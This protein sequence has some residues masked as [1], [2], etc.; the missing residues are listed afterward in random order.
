MK[1][2]PLCLRLGA[3]GLLLAMGVAAQE[4]ANPADRLKTA[5]EELR[6]LKAEEGAA[7][8]EE[9]SREM[10]R[11]ATREIARAE[12]EKLDR[13]KRD[14]KTA[15]A[16]V[17]ELGS[18]LATIEKDGAAAADP[19]RRQELEKAKAST[20]AELEAARVLAAAREE[21]VKRLTASF[22][23]EDGLYKEKQADL[24]AIQR[25]QAEKVLAA[26]QTEAK[27]CALKCELAQEA[28]K[29]AQAKP[30]PAAAEAALKKCEQ[31]R[32][33]LGQAELMV[34]LARQVLGALELSWKTPEKGYRDP[35]G[36]AKRLKATFQQL[37]SETYAAAVR[38]QG[39]LEPL[40]AGQWDEA[41]ARHLLVRAGFGGTPQEVRKLCALGLH[42]AVDYLVD[43]AFL[44]APDAPFE[45]LPPGRDDALAANVKQLGIRG[46]EGLIS[47]RQVGARDHHG[48]L[49]TWW[50]R[51]MV[52]SPRQLQE[53]LT[54]FWHG[55]FAAQFNA[56]G[57]TYAM[58]RQNQL[59]REHAAGNFGALLYGIVHDPAMLRYLDNNRNVKGK[60]NENLARELME[61]FAMGV[62]QGYTQK[63]IAEGARA[64]TG[65]TC[66]PVDGLFRFAH[67]QH[68]RGDKVIFGR[69]GPWTGDDFV[70]LILEQPS[71]SRFIAGKLYAFLAQQEPD[72]E[73]VERLA[74]VLRANTFELA[75]MLKNLFL[76]AKFYS[77][78]VRGTQIKS[79]VQLVVG[80]LKDLGIGKLTDY[81]VVDKALRE[82]G[83][84]LFEPPDVKGWRYGRSWITSAR[85]L[86]RYNRVADLVRSAPRPGGSGADVTAILDA[87]SCGSPEAVVDALVQALLIQPL[88]AE[89]RGA[90]A[91]ALGGLPPGTAWEGRKEEVNARLRN[92]LVLLMSTPEYQMF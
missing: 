90:L 67:E 45:P 69:C 64:L 38:I 9:D 42:K 40:P 34:L 83:Q 21:N 39:G 10:A 60:P 31:A 59:F 63:D 19:A 51:R 71:T 20:G 41:K 88:P 5:E 62:D 47:T 92:V 58:Y 12:G 76:S 16:L 53:K 7:R 75:P 66:D 11:S 74:S 15:E 13:A 35:D 48:S 43:Y 70:R 89:K 85:V 14:L 27:L 49:R 26:R 23:R 50:A 55:H 17:K 4:G 56:V 36:D 46:A 72:R 81:N 33:A 44:P 87:K 8:T 82:M 22:A 61:L 6:K 68:D 54:L 18:E 32:Q 57:H 77:P 30:E 65:Y 86:T 29:A 28:L 52:E 73:A 91:G 24:E 80:T 1:R 25:K 84:E 78:E 79:P 37:G 2:A 3:A